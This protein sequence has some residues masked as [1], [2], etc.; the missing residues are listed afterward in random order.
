MVL[1]SLLYFKILVKVSVT[2]MD[3]TLHSYIIKNHVKKK[4]MLNTTI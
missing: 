1:M 2:I 3:K 4:I